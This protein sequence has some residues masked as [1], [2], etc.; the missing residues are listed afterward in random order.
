MA[1][2]E[3][4]LNLLSVISSSK[5]ESVITFLISTLGDENWIVRKTASDMIFDLG[6]MVIPFLSSAL[7]SYNEDVQHWALKILT[8]FGKKGVPAILR[9]LKSANH[10]TRHFACIALGE[11]QEPLGIPAL[12]K[13]L[14]D[15]KWPVRKASSEALVKYGDQVIPAIEQVMSKTDD[16]DVR[17][18][19]IKSL[20]K[21]G[22]KAQRILLEALKT[23]NKQ[24]RYVIAAALGESGD[25]RVIK[26]LIDSLA[27][28]D[29]TIRKSATQALAEIGE[30]AL[31]PLIESLLEPNEDVRDG[32][33]LAI[34]R[35]GTS[36]VNRLLTSIESMDDNQRYLIRKSMVKMGNRLVE[37]LLRLFKSRKP[38][39][40]SFCAATLGEIGNPKSVPVLLEGLSHESWTV[41]RSCAYALGDI[42]EKGVDKIAEALKS[43]N[44]DVRYWVT[45]ILESI[46]EPGMTYLVR[47]LSDKNKS[48]RFFSAKALR[49]SNN[50]ETLRHL[51]K[52]LG[53]PSWSVRKVAAESI[54]RM[55]EVSIE[56]LLRNISNDNEDIRH[57]VGRIITEIGKSKLSQIHDCL[58][59]KDS[60]LRLYACQALGMVADQS[61]TEHLIESLRDANE[62][63]RIYAAIALG[64]IG[65][66]R[67]IVPLIR[68][69][70]D[71]NSEVH[72]NVR[73]A[74]LTLGKKVFE[75]IEK[76]VEDKDAL[77]RRN[78]AIAIGEL[79]EEKGLDLL[80]ILMADPD[81]KVRQAAAEALGVFPGLKAR[82]LLC[83]AMSDPAQSIRLAVINS[84][85]EHSMPETAMVLFDYLGKLKDDRE[86]RV[87][88]RCLANMAQKNPR[89][90]VSFFA[91]QSV[92]V[93]TI[94]AESLTQVGASII[95]ILNEIAAEISDE[96][97][98][99]W[100]QKT[101]KKL[102]NPSE[103]ISEMLDNKP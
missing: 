71:R 30:N 4:K 42:G 54:A 38:E 87:A 86:I 25:R 76:C 83:E 18:W 52:A 11:Q 75:T 33:L 101:I 85:A 12:I 61:S 94:A 6:E 58:K 100:I 46:G 23:G 27:D 5:D 62:W 35:I 103:N 44:D 28:P 39:I 16:E 55:D 80:I 36:A 88:R 21:L 7:G 9:A 49:S 14:G 60:E 22:T 31:D 43:Q 13:S 98:L 68:S 70:S 41:R 81:E 1:P 95:Q 56:H 79:A 97:I 40:M 17:F 45:R 90:F 92:A 93:R 69:L 10:D 50:P 73:K 8:R 99:F 20:G 82:T 65:D 64:K 15:E 78:S 53:D 3:K 26:V 57:W 51:I 29:W 74:F 102:K 34:V 67:A 77:L 89:M 2:R 37:P 59:T 24:L 19:A 72:R 84:L 47:A 66:E 63:T 32:C 91:N 96:T 48:I